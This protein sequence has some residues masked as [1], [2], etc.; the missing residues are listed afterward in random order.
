M[1]QKNP[2]KNG[3]QY[4]SWSWVS[5]NR[6]KLM[7]VY[8]SALGVLLVKRKVFEKVPFRTHP[9]FIN[10]EDLWYYAEAANKGFE[11]YCL[12]KRIPHKNVTWD[13][14]VLQRKKQMKIHF[15]FGLK[16]AVKKLEDLICP[17]V[18][19]N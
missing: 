14:V 5:Q 6:N 3:L 15:A 16:K 2:K 10:G 17:P 8:A 1:N 7:K 18:A 12:V 11:A 4:Y 9:T 19:R 13:K